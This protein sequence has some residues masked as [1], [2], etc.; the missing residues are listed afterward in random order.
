M[1]RVDTFDR[2]PFTITFQGH[3]AEM[4]HMAALPLW[5]RVYHAALANHC[6]DLHAPFPKPGDLACAVSPAGG[7]IPARQTIYNAVAKAKE[8]GLLCESSTTRCL[9]LKDST[10]KPGSGAQRKSRCSVDH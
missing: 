4:A 2:T 8:E 10:A 9:V 6:G 1:K 3:H 5:V 7:A